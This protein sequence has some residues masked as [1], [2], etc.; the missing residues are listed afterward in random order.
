MNRKNWDKTI[1]GLIKKDNDANDYYFEWIEFESDTH[2]LTDL[3][4]EFLG[5]GICKDV[6]VVVKGG[7][8]ILF[9]EKVKRRR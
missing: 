5:A 7:K 4:E 1:T 6:K 8:G 3:F 9:F 2:N